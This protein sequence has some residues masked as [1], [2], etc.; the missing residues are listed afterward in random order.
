MSF[1]AVMMMLSG[2]FFDQLQQSQE[3]DIR[4]VEQK[5]ATLQAEQARSAKLSAQ[6]EELNSELGERQL[7]LAE[8]NERVQRINTENGR[9]LEDNA[10]ARQRY[11]DLLA[12]LHESNE[13]LYAARLAPEGSV[14]ERRERVEYLKARL[15]EQVDVLLR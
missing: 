15:K 7:S 9:T 5:Q 4:R 1:A 2:C 14:E 6:E 13:Q 8:L 11:H 10:A 3:N 12:Q